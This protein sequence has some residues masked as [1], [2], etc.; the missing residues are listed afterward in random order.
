MSQDLSVR[1]WFRGLHDRKHLRRVPLPRHRRVALRLRLRYKPVDARPGDPRTEVCGLLSEQRTSPCER[2]LHNLLRD[3]FRGIASLE[4]ERLRPLP[5]KHPELG[6]RRRRMRSRVSRGKAHLERLRVRGLLCRV[7]VRRLPVL[8]PDDREVRGQVSDR[9]TCKQQYVLNVRR[10]DR[11]REA[12]LG[13]GYC[14]LRRYVQGVV[15]ERAMP[16]V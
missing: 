10:S 1:L 11:K 8:E 6:P 3:E 13:P 2:L 4:R 5:R 14:S 16:A 12:L 9:D 15:A 7:P